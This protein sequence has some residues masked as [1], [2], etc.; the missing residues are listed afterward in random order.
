M[1]YPVMFAI[2][3]ELQTLLHQLSGKTT[4]PILA[5][6]ILDLWASSFKRGYGKML[7]VTLSEVKDFF[8]AAALIGAF[9][10]AIWLAVKKAVLPIEREVAKPVDPDTNVQQQQPL[11]QKFEKVYDAIRD[12]SRD[13][14][15]MRG[16]L[17]GRLSAQDDRMLEGDKD[18]KEVLRELGRLKSYV[19]QLEKNYQ[20][21]RRQEPR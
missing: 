15:T 4:G 14:R 11:W 5:V 17:D 10:G 18:R 7:Q 8:T 20:R 6:T 21:E 19:V 1:N 9:A 2:R 12:L 3:W 16:D 13:M